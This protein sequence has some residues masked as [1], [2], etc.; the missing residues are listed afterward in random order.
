MKPKILFLLS[1]SLLAIS[2]YTHAL[3]SGPF[4]V[5][6]RLEER[7]SVPHIVVDFEIPE[8]HYLYAHEH[9]ITLAE[10][11]ELVEV[12]VPSSTR[13]FDPFLEKEIDIFDSSASFIYRLGETE[14]PSVT[15]KVRFQGCNPD[16]CFAP[17]NREIKLALTDEPESETATAEVT[18]DSDDVSDSPLA[19]FVETGRASG[20]MASA[21][22]IDF[23]E[24][25]E[26]GDFQADGAALFA[27]RGVLAIVV[28]ILLGG[29]ALNL[30]PCVLPMIPVN[31][32]ILG[33]G[34]QAKSKMRG[35]LL[36]S[37]YGAGIALA[38][39]AL[40]LIVLLTGARFGALNASPVFNFGIA[41]LFAVLALAM[42][43]V[44]NIDLS[45][46]QGGTGSKMKGGRFATAFVFGLVAAL[47]AGACV[48]PVV[49]SVL[50]YSTTL[51][52]EGNAVAIFLPFLLGLGMALPWPFA[53]AGLSFLPKSGAWMEKV[54]YAFGIVILVAAV[55]YAKLGFTLLPAS[56]VAADDAVAAEKADSLWLT[57]LEEA[58][59][60]A[61]ETGKPIFIDFWAVWCSACMRMDRTTF[62]DPAVLERLS[63]YVMLKLDADDQRRSTQYALER[64][65]D[66][67]LPT[68]A[69]VELENE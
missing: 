48:A 53:G 3:F 47:L 16:V 39:G 41:I 38:Y 65:V 57:S 10:D 52:A 12:E 37:T 25:V 23:L 18:A 51:Y 24:A 5:E 42:F 63:D 21:P 17:T 60:A 58:V 68:Y 44:F 32:A 29:L 7:E 8:D 4:E 43:G 69:I 28:I 13:K 67:G 46:F 45:R 22:F 66:V 36:G 40:G 11:V 34:S 49:I 14:L 30:T 59:V 62:R 54:K 56:P 26:S 20:Y 6:A 27:G 61:R 55:Y 35:F 2:T 15:V 33:A 50:L 1:F 19:G 31:I 64:F 9:S